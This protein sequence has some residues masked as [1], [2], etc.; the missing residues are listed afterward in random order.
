M[1]KHIHDIISV[2]GANNLVS[3]DQCRSERTIDG[4]L[5]SQVIGGTNDTNLAV[6]N[7]QVSNTKETTIA[8][9]TRGQQT[10]VAPDC[11]SSN[12]FA[13]S[14]DCSTS[15]NQLARNTVENTTEGDS[16]QMSQ[17]DISLPC[18]HAVRADLNC[19]E[20]TGERGCK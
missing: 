6:N 9:A 4:L 13:N 5:D 1:N 20:L 19:N 11:N 14:V 15:A 3:K 10:Q 7:K 16:T 2:D 17:E 8:V 12:S 18:G